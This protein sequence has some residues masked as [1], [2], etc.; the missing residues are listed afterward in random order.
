MQWF[1]DNFWFTWYW[2]CISSWRRHCQA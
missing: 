2:T 1:M